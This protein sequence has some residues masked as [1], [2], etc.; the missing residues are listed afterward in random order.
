MSKHCQLHEPIDFHIMHPE[1]TK[2]KVLGSMSPLPQP[3]ILSQAQAPN[4]RSLTDSAS[5]MSTGYSQLLQR[6]QD[7]K[8]DST[9]RENGPNSVPL[10]SKMSFENRDRD[11]SNRNETGSINGQLI[12]KNDT[13]NPNKSHAISTKLLSITDSGNECFWKT[14]PPAFDCNG[15]DGEIYNENIDTYRDDDNE[16]PNNVKKKSLLIIMTILMSQIPKTE[17]L[18]QTNS[19]ASFRTINGTVDMFVRELQYKFNKYAR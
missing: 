10:L 6:D 12:C 11:Q 18:L 13:S 1:K 14:V 3:L 7:D 17:T 16:Q 5:P 2:E 8:F 9:G 4:T 19:A 15:Q